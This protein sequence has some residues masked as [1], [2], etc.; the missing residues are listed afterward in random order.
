MRWLPALILAA[1]AGSGC[2][3]HVSGH[4]DLL[5]K[6]LRTVAVLPFANVTMRYK[7][8]EHLPADITREFNRRTRY[9]VIT[10]GGQAD[11]VLTGT[12][13]NFTAYPTTTD[14]ISGRATAVQAIVQMN[15]T[16]TERATGT[17]LFSR[18]GMEVRERF[19]ISID[20][21]AYFDES[22]AAMVRLSRA[23]GQ[24]VVT[25]VLEKF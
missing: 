18:P 7:L 3:Y 8:A 25:A 22:G 6:K 19:E 11:A 14:P 2:G 21:Q 15:I 24:S 5:P 17:V 12:L 10:D 13:V 23:V 9:K 16:L 1:S 20:P 4:G